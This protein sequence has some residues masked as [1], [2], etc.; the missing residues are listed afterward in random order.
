[1]RARWHKPPMVEVR[2][3]EAHEPHIYIYIYISVLYDN[4]YIY[5]YYKP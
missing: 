1:M 5:I 3:Y 4:I 2:V